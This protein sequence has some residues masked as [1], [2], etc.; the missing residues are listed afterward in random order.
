MHNRTSIIVAA[1]MVIAAT[2]GASAFDEAHYQKVKNGAR[3]CTWCDLKGADFRNIRLSG[4]DLSGADLTGANMAD[5]ALTKID[6]SGA[7]LTSAVVTG[8]DLSGTNLKGADLD[9]VDLSNAILKGAQIETAYCD[10]ATR[11]PENSG[12]VCS[13]VTIQHK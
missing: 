2:S 13:G 9:Q 4:V 1:L 7:D 6:L 11:L 3:S 12:Y 5:A 10:W 8:A